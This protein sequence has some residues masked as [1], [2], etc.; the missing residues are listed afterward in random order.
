M[1]DDRTYY[2]TG[3][4]F[5]EEPAGTSDDASTWSSCFL[6]PTTTAPVVQNTLTGLGT[7]RL[8]ILAEI[9]SGL[10]DALS[11]THQHAHSSTSGDAAAASSEVS[12]ADQTILPPTAPQIS[13]E[14]LDDTNALPPPISYVE[15]VDDKVLSVE[16]RTQ[17]WLPGHWTEMAKMATKAT[18]HITEFLLPVAAGYTQLPSE[19]KDPVVEAY[20]ADSNNADLLQ[21][22]D[23]L[24][25]WDKAMRAADRYIKNRVA[26]DSRE[27]LAKIVANLIM[28][29]AAVERSRSNTS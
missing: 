18:H 11:E 5:A 27:A 21:L 23:P 22:I 14:Q 13:F 8:D 26:K 1:P 15:F 7:S 20:T 12:L 16:E 28:Q 17:D 25:D 2:W 9:A 6:P 29:A 3:D 10:S 4:R 24:S 19:A